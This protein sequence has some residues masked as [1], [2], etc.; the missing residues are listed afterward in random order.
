MKKIILLLILGICNYK[1][2]N[3]QITLDSTVVT[4]TVVAQNLDVPWEILWG[5][6]DNI[7]FTERGGKVS[8]LDPETSTIEVLL[9]IDDVAEVS[10]SGLLGMVLHPNFLHPDSQFVYLVYTYNAPSRT[11]RLVRYT[12]D[13]D[14]LI[15]R[16]IL[17]DNIPANNNHS[18]SRVIITPD[19]KILMSTGDAQNSSNSQDT[20]SLAGKFLRI[21]LD[22]TIP[23][24]NPISGNYLW[25]L[26]HRNAQGL[27][28]AP[29]GMIYSSEHGP[30]NDDEINI[31]TKNRN[32]GWP[33][34]EGYCDLAAEQIFCDA[35][36]VI[37]P[38]FAWTPTLA[39]AGLDYYDH[40]AIP[41]W[42]NALLLTSLKQ[43]DFRVLRL[44][45]AG[46]SIIDEDIY[47]NN[48]YGR[49]RDICV[50]PSG[51]IYISTSNHDGRANSGFPVTE[52]DRIIKLSNEN[53]NSVKERPSKEDFK[54]KLYPNPA[55]NLLYINLPNG[56]CIKIYDLTFREVFNA[57]F[58]GTIDVSNLSNGIYIIEVRTDKATFR[59]KF[60]KE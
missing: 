22:G 46:D 31:I 18:G 53:Y 14:T 13:T 57:S 60:L 9:E 47:L 42:R 12:Y 48:S 20:A 7:W 54:L 23:D 40:E 35:N 21:N 4:Q 44:N 1:F 50:S 26:G 15:D 45:T 43:D 2:S 39:V 25:S 5:P 52:D 27:V 49:L 56:I 16:Q 30:V 19:R 59:G 29:S 28:R 6:D 33:D 8:R 38:I 24:D 17:L 58:S 32:Y 10:E 34:V 41:E 3:A 51:D 55:E 36:N 11:E 37:E